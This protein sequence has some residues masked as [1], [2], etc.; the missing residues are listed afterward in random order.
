MDSESIKQIHQRFPW[1]S[2]ST[3]EDA[4]KSAGDRNE[5]LKR[6]VKQHL[7][8][9][10]DELIDEMEKRTTGLNAIDS[11]TKRIQ[12]DTKKF[13]SAI[14]RI[15]DP[16]TGAAAMLELGANAIDSLGSSIGALGSRIP[17]IGPLVSALGTTSG[18]VAVIGAATAA[19]FAKIASQQDKVIRSMIDLGF[20]T[21]D[22]DQYNNI[23]SY[24][25]NVGMTIEDFIGATT[26][27]N[28]MF[29]RN[30][31]GIVAG[32]QSF[33]QFVSQSRE[34][35]ENGLLPDYGYSPKELATRLI[36]E[37]EQLYMLG[38]IDQLDTQA[39]NKI[40][41]N[42][43]KSSETAS[44]LGSEMSDQRS[45]LL[46]ARDEISENMDFRR[47][48]IVNATEIADVF[49][50]NGEEVLRER[51]SIVNAMNQSIF[52]K[53]EFSESIVNSFN[54]FLGNFQFDQTMIN[55][56]DPV[57]RD[58]ITRMGVMPQ[59]EQVVSALENTETTPEDLITVQNNFIQALA[60]A[61]GRALTSEDRALIAQAETALQFLPEANAAYKSSFIQSLTAMQS[62]N[63]ESVQVEG[64]MQI[65]YAELRDTAEPRF[66]TIQGG[67]TGFQSALSDSVD[68]MQE[69]F[70]LKTE[71][72]SPPKKNGQMN[73]QRVPE[74]TENTEFLDSVLKFS[75]QYGIDPA[76]ALGIAKKESNFDI[77]AIGDRHLRNKA[78]GAFQMRQPALDEVYNRYGVR[79]TESDMMDSTKAAQAA[80][81]YMAIQ[82]DFYGARNNTDIARMYNGGP[83]GVQKTSTLSYG[84]SV[85]QN[86]RQIRRVLDMYPDNIKELNHLE[87]QLGMV[88]DSIANKLQDGNIRE[89][90]YGR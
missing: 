33:A 59:F 43:K 8:V 67:L 24:S 65:A 26:D 53:G 46:R 30:N 15:D 7:D 10:L 89:M 40:I 12:D 86:Q 72:V 44:Y 29:A 47:A 56:I 14:D 39:K 23:R 37:A 84:N 21:S 90:E 58:M 42:F 75:D 76:L 83:T 73:R 81:M 3:I 1:A 16:L 68:V 82:R 57:L 25:A 27:L 20:V 85:A 52:G 60:G 28:G 55:D 41:E 11:V 64:E 61:S 62:A 51:I 54:N 4:L 35:V 36:E 48:L 50:E 88:S 45:S 80:I 38:E 77:D 49:G 34:M 2:Q 78:Y 87:Q 79:F 31:N 69:I 63:S 9:D 17:Y 6:M 19:T 71:P 5:T 66:K 32:A 18:K 70:G 22:L 13:I 74:T